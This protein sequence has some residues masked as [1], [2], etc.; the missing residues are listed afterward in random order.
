MNAEGLA[1]AV[2]GLR[3]FCVAVIFA[4]EHAQAMNGV[5]VA[6]VRGCTV[7]RDQGELARLLDAGGESVG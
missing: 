2:V 5:P 4:D 1:C 6:L 3:Q 7:A